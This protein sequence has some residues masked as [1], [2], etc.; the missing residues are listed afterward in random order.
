M[1]VRQEDRGSSEPIPLLLCAAS[2]GL[3]ER[4]DRLIVERDRRAPMALLAD[5]VEAGR[6]LMTAQACLVVG[7][8]DDV[9]ATVAALPAGRGVGQRKGPTA[10]G[11]WAR[12]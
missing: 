3:L 11:F 12:L 9:V 8:I 10:V 2:V 1:T 5:E 7:E 6:R 4:V